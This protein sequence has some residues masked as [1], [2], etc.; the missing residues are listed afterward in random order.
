MTIWHLAGHH[1]W[2]AA[3]QQGEHHRSTR[4]ATIVEAA[5]IP[6][7]GDEWWDLLDVAG[8]TTGKRVRRGVLCGSGPPLSRRQ[9][10]ESL[11]EAWVSRG[12]PRWGRA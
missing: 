6:Q 2:Y 9:G 10:C 8:R 4:G 12:C 7:G 3:R 11:P 1:D 5:M